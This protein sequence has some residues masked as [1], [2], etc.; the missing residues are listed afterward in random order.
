LSWEGALVDALP[1]LSNEFQHFQEGTMFHSAKSIAEN[2]AARH[3]NPGVVGSIEAGKDKTASIEAAAIRT[4]ALPAGKQQ[5]VRATGGHFFIAG[6]LVKDGEFV[7]VQRDIATRLKSSG[8]A[9][10]VT[11][12]E[13][14]E[15]AGSKGKK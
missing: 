9:E 10:F 4:A 3:P 13:V 8:Q 12:A 14:A 6:E 2:F 15:A 5:W 1:N 7:Q 11:D